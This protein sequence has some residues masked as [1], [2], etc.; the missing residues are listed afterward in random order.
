MSYTPMTQDGVAI[1]PA[2]LVG[3]S[4]RLAYIRKVYSLLFFG[5]VAF[6][7]A[8]ALPVYGYIAGIQPLASLCVAMCAIPWYAALAVIL[9]SSFVV[10]AVA[11]VRVVNLIGFFGFAVV[12]GLLT[13]NLV[14]NAMFQGVAEGAGSAAYQQALISGGV[15]LMQAAGMTVLVFGGLSAYVFIT[16]KDF[17]FMG[18]F[19]TAGLFVVIGS[20]V[21]AGIASMLGYDMSVVQLAISVTAVVLF[22]GYVLFDTSNI[23][24]HYATDMVVPGALALLVDFIILFRN[25]LFLLMRARD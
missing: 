10:H 5:I 6:A 11:M 25:I 1:R 22:S 15:V 2:A 20:V 4:E 13:V 21:I 12:W 9:V 8:A 24:N 3:A 18:G 23:L 17:S 14:A 7:A 19:L 16:R